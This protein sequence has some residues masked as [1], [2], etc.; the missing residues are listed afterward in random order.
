MAKGKGLEKRFE[1]HPLWSFLHKKRNGSYE[2]IGEDCVVLIDKNKDG[3]DIKIQ[4]SNHYFHE[5]YVEGENQHLERGKKPLKKDYVVT[6]NIK[7]EFG[8]TGF[9]H[10]IDLQNFPLPLNPSIKMSF[11]E[12]THYQIKNGPA[13]SDQ[14]SLFIQEILD[15]VFA[16]IKSS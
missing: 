4:N 14:Y 9:S 1:L 6:Q 16:K 13:L 11:G 5:S 8:A 12:N 7:Y 15:G 3:V 10:G 2:Y